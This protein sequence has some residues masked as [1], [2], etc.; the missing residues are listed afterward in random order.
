MGAPVERY[1]FDPFAPVPPEQRRDVY[2]TPGSERKRR[3]SG[4]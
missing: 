2:Y 3:C 1:R 4:S